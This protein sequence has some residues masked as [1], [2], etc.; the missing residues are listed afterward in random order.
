MIILAG[1]WPIVD[2]K[3]SFAYSFNVM[4]M[5]R[6]S[7]E[8]GFFLRIWLRLPDPWIMTPLSLKQAKLDEVGTGK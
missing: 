1:S 4:R 3:Q 6:G 5:G 7:D 8:L 2:A